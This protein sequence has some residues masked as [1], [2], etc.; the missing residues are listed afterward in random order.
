MVAAVLLK[1]NVVVIFATQRIRSK[2]DIRA[3]F[4]PKAM[5]TEFTSSMYEKTESG[6][7]HITRGEVV[8]PWMA[9]DRTCVRGAEPS[10]ASLLPS[11]PR[12]SVAELWSSR[13]GSPLRHVPS[14]QGKFNVRVKALEYIGGQ[15]VCSLPE[16][17]RQGVIH[18]KPT[19]L[20][21]SLKVTASVICDV[22]P[23]EQVCGGACCRE[24]SSCWPAWGGNALAGTCGS[25]ST[26]HR[27]SA[28]AQPGQGDFHHYLYQAGPVVLRQSLVLWAKQICLS[29][30]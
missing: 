19:S 26:P 1:I 21:D 15:H 8:S 27:R 30:S 9:L 3:D 7:F 12:V 2:M 5:K 16:K 29:D 20:S 24:M 18:V 25:R 13:A 22:C 6:S 11:S 28:E 17:D 10:A 4:I 14:F 23:C